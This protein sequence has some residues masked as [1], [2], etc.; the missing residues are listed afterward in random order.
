MTVSASFHGFFPRGVAR[1]SVRMTVRA[2]AFRAP[3]FRDPREVSDVA[4]VGDG[5]PRTPTQR[6]ATEDRRDAGN[7]N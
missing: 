2:V 3:R 7:L 6:G 4:P 1:L 5:D